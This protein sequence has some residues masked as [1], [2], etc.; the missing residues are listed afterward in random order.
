MRSRRVVEEEFA[1]YTIEKGQSTSFP[2]QA[3]S[4]ASAIYWGS[5]R[6]LRGNPNIDSV[7]NEIAVLFDVSVTPRCYPWYVMTDTVRGAI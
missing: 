6:I 5:V 4:M 7:D 1:K 2:Y 3:R